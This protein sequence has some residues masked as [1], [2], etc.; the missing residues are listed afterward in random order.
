[1]QASLPRL[2]RMVSVED[3]GQGSESLRILGIKWLPTGAASQTVTADGK[4]QKSDKNKGSGKNDRSVSGQGELENNEDDDK[5]GQALERS[6]SS[7]ERKQT[8]QE[9]QNISEGMEAEEGE[10]VNLEV[11][12][13][14][15]ARSDGKGLRN[16]SKNAHLYLGFYLPANVKVPVW[17]E[18][19]GLVGVMRLRLQLTPD[20][21]FFSLCTLTFLGQPK[22]DMSCVP[23]VK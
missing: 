19:Q 22:V 13:A 6:E 11:A 9:N 3:I 14:Y 20:P 4:L 12:F 23:L 18:L 8:E 1:M 5:D 2:V 15:K 16:R 17:V 7:E 21:P 10:F